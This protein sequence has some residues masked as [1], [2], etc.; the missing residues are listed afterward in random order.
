M[1]KIFVSILSAAVLCF[2]VSCENLDLFPESEAALSENEVFSSYE[3]Y[4]GFF[5]K[6][7]LAM[8]CETQGSGHGGDDLAKW[9][10]GRSTFLRAMYW[11]QEATSDEMYNRSGSGYGLRNATALNWEPGTEFPSWLYYRSYLIISYANELL[12]RTEENVLKENGVY[13]ACRN[14]VGYWRAEARFIRAYM[15]YILMDSFGDIGFVDNTVPNGTYP[16]Q[17]TRK[18]IYDYIVK[19][20]E[21]I[22]DDLVPAGQ[23]IW[24][25]ANQAS[26]WFLL[27]RTLLGCH[28]YAGT[29]TDYGKALE[30]CRKIITSGAFSLAPN[31]IENFLADNDTSNEIIWGL[32]CDS[33][34]AIGSGG[35]N[36]LIKANLHAPMIAGGTGL[37]FG[38]TDQW[39]GNHC[40][41][42]TFVEKFEESD[43]DFHYDDSW[44]DRKKDHR[45]LLFMGPETEG[46]IDGGNAALVKELYADADPTNTTVKGSA[47]YGSLYTKWRNVRK[48]RVVR[49]PSNYSSVGF[50]VMRLADVY[51]MAA[52]AIMRANGGSP[53]AEALG[54]VNEVRERA[55][56]SGKYYQAD[57]CNADGAITLGELTYAWLLDERS[58]E[59]WSENWRRSDLVRFN[60]YT[61]NYSWDFKGY[62]PND[63]G[64]SY[65]GIKDVNDKYNVFPIPQDDVRYNPNLRQ[66]PAYE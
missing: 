24:G 46:K 48:D 64:I 50:P 21:D 55:Y 17:K 52:E 31:Y 58:R 4:H 7:Y 36:Y 8:V 63:K 14:E 15:Y 53:D 22:Q 23:K 56:C 10:A 44:G 54:Y 9:D 12:R 18:E 61:K 62:M 19:E 40:L 65:Y 59:L 66:N 16:V 1:K 60:C 29:T 2:A 34:R 32:A 6:C 51:L 25:R 20:L 41:R 33:N 57:K 37:D 45:A 49:D 35:T 11:S 3:G 26:A 47:P 42:Q 43:R 38:I 30:Y 5:L 27:A 28:V 13:E 39:G